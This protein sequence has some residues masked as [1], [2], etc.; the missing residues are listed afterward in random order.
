M[1]RKEPMPTLA[2]WRRAEGLTQVEAAKIL[3][4]D[5][6]SYSRWESGRWYPRRLTARAISDRTGVPVVTLLGIA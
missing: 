1:K 6:G 5:Q 4:T 3:G 2:A